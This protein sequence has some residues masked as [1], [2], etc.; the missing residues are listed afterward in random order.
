MLSDEEMRVLTAAAVV[1]HRHSEESMA[2]D[3][4]SFQLHDV[5]A[6]AGDDVMAFIAAAQHLDESGAALL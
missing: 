5:V 4:L 1:A 2:A 3:K 6:D